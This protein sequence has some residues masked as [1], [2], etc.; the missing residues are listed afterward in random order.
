MTFANPSYLWAL[1]GLA[2]PLAIHLLSRKEGKVIRVGSL[3]HVEESN[4]SQFKSIRLNEI[5]LLLLRSLMVTALV[6]FLSGAQCSNPPG[7]GEVKWLMVEAGIE[8]D[9]GY[10]SRI[11]SLKSAGYD[12][13][14]FLKGDYWAIAEQ[15][16]ELPHE[17]VVISYS[18]LEG[19]NGERITLPENIRWI[20]AEQ[21]G[22]V[23][24]ATAWQAG[25]TVF[26]RTARSTSLETSYSTSIGVPDSLEIIKPQEISVTI[27]A[28]DNAEA[29]ILQAALNVL[30]SEYKL[31]IKILTP[32]TTNNEQQT[33]TWVFW[34]RQA[35]PKFSGD[36]QVVFSTPGSGALIER[37]S[38]NVLHLNR[39]LDQDVA[40]N[41]NLVI[42]LF[43]TL[44]PD[45]K[46]PQVSKEKDARSLPDQL[47][48]SAAEQTGRTNASPAHAGIEK[49]LILLFLL[50]LGAERFVAIRRNQ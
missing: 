10:K 18:R 20:S 49:Y 48:W 28:D 7:A 35:K 14:E 6:F 41:E 25:D 37:I 46:T 19:F 21:P 47:A 9:P 5:L 36:Q 1:V 43:K 42:E 13:H 27:S 24:P 4:T 45:L 8:N 23:F 40:L 12:Q 44:Y 33:T 16:G 17:V 31:P 3:R 26:V 11:D 30:R 2:I 34:L 50:S 22:N 39:K 38:E 29:G 15:L 32:R